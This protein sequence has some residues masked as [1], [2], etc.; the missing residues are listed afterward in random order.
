MNL[1]FQALY[2]NCSNAMDGEIQQVIFDTI[3][4]DPDAEEYIRKSPYVLI[5]RNFEFSGESTIE[6]HDGNDDEGGASISSVLLESKRI[7]VILDKQG[8][9]EITF[10]LNDKQFEELKKHLRNMLV[11]R[12]KN[13]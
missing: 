4:D 6:W 8:T 12:L 10:H 3:R 11:S 2:V 7:F 9:I 5:S 1:S 13:Q